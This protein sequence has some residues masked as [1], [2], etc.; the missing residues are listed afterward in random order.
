MIISAHAQER[1]KR[2]ERKRGEK[3]KKRTYICRP[4]PLHDIRP[5]PDIIRELVTFDD[6]LASIGR[7]QNAP[8]MPRP[9]QQRSMPLNLPPL[10]RGRV[11]GQTPDVSYEQHAQCEQRDAVDDGGC[12]EVRYEPGGRA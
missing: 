12:K 3:R 2:K 7:R 4:H 11:D 10:N 9:P 8:K 1:L 6:D 5:N